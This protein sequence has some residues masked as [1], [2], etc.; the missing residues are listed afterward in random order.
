[1][2]KKIHLSQTKFCLVFFKRSNKLILGIGNT[3][4]KFVSSKSNK[5]K[6]VNNLTKKINKQLLKY[7]V[8][9]YECFET[10][11]LEEKEFLLIQAQSKIY[12]VEF[13][14]YALLSIS[15]VTLSLR[16]LI[17]NTF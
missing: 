4:A 17:L 12:N 2:S 13:Y 10:A 3:T 1:M 6:A 14:L 15:A 7:Y 5:M 8:S 9:K 11:T 16:L